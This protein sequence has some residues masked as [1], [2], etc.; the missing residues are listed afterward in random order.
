MS[1]WKTLVRDDLKSILADTQVAAIIESFAMGVDVWTP[2]ATS[3][4]ATIRAACGKY[5]RFLSKT[6]LSVPP[7]AVTY[8][9]WLILEQAQPRISTLVLS[10]DQKA[11]IKA[12]HD[13]LDRLRDKEDPIEAVTMPDDPV[14]SE[15]E[16]QQ[17]TKASVSVPSRNVLF[18]RQTMAGL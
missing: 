4:V 3:V 2:N 14:G 9:L 17:S 8:A 16:V 12:A 13:W 15:S 6:P 7:E 18:T 11:T 10:G 1:A 5:G